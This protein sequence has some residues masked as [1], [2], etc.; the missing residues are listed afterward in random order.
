MHEGVVV[1]V[2]IHARVC[3]QVGGCEVLQMNICDPQRTSSCWRHTGES[4]CHDYPQA[5]S[6]PCKDRKKSDGTPTVT[7]TVGILKPSCGF[8]LVLQES[9]LMEVKRCCSKTGFRATK[10]K[11]TCKIVWLEEAL[12]LQ[13]LQEKWKENKST[14]NVWKSPQRWR[15]GEKTSMSALTDTTDPYLYALTINYSRV[16][17]LKTAF[18]TVSI[19]EQME[20]VSVL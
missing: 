13:Q 8:C 19:S 15:C 7:P 12:R 2:C 17:I 5:V 1:C 16:L 20:A 6:G 10:R 18:V 3:A 11:Q 14:A 9:C 4:W